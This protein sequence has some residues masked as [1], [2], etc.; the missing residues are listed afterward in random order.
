M[1]QLG[2]CVDK[3]WVQKKVMAPGCEPELC[4]RIFEALRQVSWG[5]SLA[6]A[7]GGGFMYV[8]LKEEMTNGRVRELIENL[9]GCEKMEVYDVEIDDIGMVCYEAPIS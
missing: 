9:E 5:M 4:C 6:G 3:Y 1:A 2:A 8:L 7:G